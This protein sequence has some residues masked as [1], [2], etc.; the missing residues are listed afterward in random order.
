MYLYKIITSV[1]KLYQKVPLRPSPSQPF[2]FTVTTILALIF[3]FK[4]L[5][6]M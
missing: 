1:K 3:A 5:A 2:S 6:V 4:N